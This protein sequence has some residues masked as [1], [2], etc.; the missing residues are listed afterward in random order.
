MNNENVK[1]LIKMINVGQSFELTKNYTICIE[2]DLKGQKTY[3]LFRKIPDEENDDQIELLIR[4][5]N[6]EELE[7]LIVK[8]YKKESN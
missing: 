6:E 5:F 7:R 1:R 8:F 2:L 3:A 4:E